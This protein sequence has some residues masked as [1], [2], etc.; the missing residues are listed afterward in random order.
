MVNMKHC[1]KTQKVI[2]VALR[3]PMHIGNTLLGVVYSFQELKRPLKCSHNFIF[4]F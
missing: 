3:L 4:E 1:K 2:F